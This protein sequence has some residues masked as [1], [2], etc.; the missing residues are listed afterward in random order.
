MLVL[1][2][3]DDAPTAFTLPGERAAWQVVVDTRSASTRVESLPE[4]QTRYELIPRSMAVLRLAG[5]PIAV[6]PEAAV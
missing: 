1:L 2:N 4:G 3:A 5:E 6:E